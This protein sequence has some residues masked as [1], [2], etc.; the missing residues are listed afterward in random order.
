[1]YEFDFSFPN[2]FL[3]DFTHGIWLFCDLAAPQFH[4]DPFAAIAIA[5][6]PRNRPVQT[7]SSAIV[8]SP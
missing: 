8:T 4:I 1:M 7:F 2:E 6:S 5:L 3:P